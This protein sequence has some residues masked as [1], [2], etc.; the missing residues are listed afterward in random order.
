MLGPWEPTP[1]NTPEPKAKDPIKAPEPKTVSVSSVLNKKTVTTIA[2]TAIP[3]FRMLR[4]K[5]NNVPLRTSATIRTL[6]ADQ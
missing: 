3:L 4:K 1:E 5:Q 2:D 6:S